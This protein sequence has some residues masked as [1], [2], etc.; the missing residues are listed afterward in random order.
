M[1]IL[2][3]YK[4]FYDFLSGVWGADPKLILDR[5]KHSQ[6]DLSH[7]K[8]NEYGSLYICGDK[9]DFAYKNGQFLYLS[10]LEKYYKPAITWFGRLDNDACK[11]VTITNNNSNGIQHSICSEITIDKQEYNKANNCPIILELNGNQSLFLFPKLSDLQFNKV[12]AP[13]EIY[14]KLSEW[15]SPK[16]NITDNRTNLEKIITHGFDKITSFRKTK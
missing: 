6:P 10:D 3:T 9:Y 13:E 11:K 7:I 14:I 16:E 4:D 5:R 15:L 12:M 1:L 8:D 2:S